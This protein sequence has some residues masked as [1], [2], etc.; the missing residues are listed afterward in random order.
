M[1]KYICIYIVSVFISSV[2]QI[3]LKIS[4]NKEYDNLIK[5]YLNP[6]VIVAYGI[7]FCSSILTI[8]AYRAVPLSMGPVIESL[9][10]I[11]VTAMGYLWLKETVSRRKILGIAFILLGIIIFYI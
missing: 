6:L 9:G 11:F 7:F 1:I 10:Y 4:S 5:E 3:L 2:S 8:V